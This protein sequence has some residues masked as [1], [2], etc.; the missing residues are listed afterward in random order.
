MIPF[1]PD[2]VNAAE[3]KSKQT[4]LLLPFPKV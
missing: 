1:E 3:G 2:A 4:S